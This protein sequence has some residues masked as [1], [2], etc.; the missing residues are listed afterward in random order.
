V[1]ASMQ[2]K[3]VVITGAASGQG[4]AGALRFADAGADLALCDIDDIGLQQ[5]AELVAHKSDVSV[6]ALRCDLADMSDLT[7]FAAAVTD[8]FDVVDVVYNNAG[9]MLRASIEET[10]EE[11]WDRVNAINVKAPFFLVK[12][13]LPAL[14]RSEAGAVINVSSISA[15]TPPRDG[16]TVYCASKGALTAL[17]RA[18]ARDLW[19]YGI[20]VNCLLPGAIDTPMPAAAF[21]K[22]PVENRAA[23]RQAAVAHSIIQRFAAPDEVA[24]VAVFLAGPD[25]SF[26]TGAV[27]PVDGGWTAV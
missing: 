20:R 5:T 12:F 6:L 10:T 23:A 9:V 22:L 15:A 1:T 14:R 3:V 27:V 26:M 18:Q 7:S 21:D 13:L 19:H 24:A 11:D 4:R 16:N 17:T 8:R 2:G 25:A